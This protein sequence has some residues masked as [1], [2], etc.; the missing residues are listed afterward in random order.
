MKKISL[1]ISALFIVF[2][3]SAQSDRYEQRYDLLV[4]QFGPAG[5]GVETVLNNWEKVDSTNAKMLLGRFH[6][7]FEKSRSAQVEP[8]PSKKYLG[9][10]PM[11]TLK[12]S[13]GNDIHYYQIYTYDDILYGEAIKAVD[14]AIA[15]WPDRLDFRFVKANAYIAYEQESPDMALAS[16][17]SLIDEN[18]SRISPWVYD[19]EEADKAFFEDAM[20]E[21]CYSFYA[22][23]TQAAYEA[24]LTLSTR[25]SQVF[26]ANYG[27]INNIGSYYMVAKEDYK[28]ACRYY[29]KV[30]KA[31]PDNY[32]A[33]RNGI[34]ASRKV[35]NVKQEKKYLEMMVKHGPEKESMQAQ[36]RLKAL[37]GK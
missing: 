34:L 11:L 25:L 32:I 37:G 23:G 7:W 14:K 22:L 10:E 27:F 8:R 1:I 35:R 28:T 21:Y 17:L 26:P 6:Y 20:Q 12:D 15:I 29:N 31:E 18:S 5:V 4:S 30:L 33:I 2:A 9:M 19:T 3:A 24:F 36:S 16:L 13:T